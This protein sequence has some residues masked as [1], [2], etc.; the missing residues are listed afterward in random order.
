MNEKVIP[1]VPS[2]LTDQVPVILQAEPE[3]IEI[4]LQRMAFMV[5]DMQNAFVSKGG[6]FD[7]WGFDISGCQKIFEPI[8]KITSV[9]RLKGCKIIYIAN[10]FSPDLR[11]F[12]PPDSAIRYKSGGALSY[13]EHPEW[14]DKLTV[15]GRWGADIIEQLK[16]Q[17]G[18][19]LVEKARRSAFFGTNLDI[20]LKSFSI[21]YLAFM[22]VATNVCVE[23]TLRDAS[24]IGYWPI[25][26][27]DACVNTGPPFIQEATIFNVQR[28]FGW[29]TT[30]EN[31]IKAMEQP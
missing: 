8:K 22:G 20:I 13:L 1:A 10:T 25:L 4:N 28:S 12:G 29:V 31:I 19:I 15:R 16:P 9:A 2:T 27:S 11:E 30:T 17:E 14:E 24:Y 5:I 7:L 26:I 3:P 18:D 21:N 23:S 6:M